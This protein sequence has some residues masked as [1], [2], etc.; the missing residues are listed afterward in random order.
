[1]SAS[2]TKFVFFVIAA[3]VHLKLYFLINNYVFIKSYFLALTVKE[4]STTTLG[5]KRPTTPKTTAYPITTPILGDKC[6]PARPHIPHPT[7]CY[8]FYH[9]VD[10]LHGVEHV[11]KSCAPPTMFNPNAMVCD[12]AESVIKIRPECGAL[13]PKPH[14]PKESFVEETTESR[15]TTSKPRVT[16]RT[17]TFTPLSN[18]SC[19]PARPHIPHPAS[20]FIFYHC[21]DRLHGVEHVE[22]SCAPPTMFNPNTMVCDWAESVM[23]IRPECGAPP[24]PHPPSENLVEGETTE[25]YPDYEF[26]DEQTQC[27]TGFTWKRCVHRCNQVII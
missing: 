1:M 20:C 11:E 26:T 25:E 27:P 17:T 24:K 22:K 5:P 9:C 3:Q 7:N 13:P 19:D 4:A 2:I 8:I 18:G 12:W 10:R 23:K 14:P 6:D 21:V 15:S 16:Q